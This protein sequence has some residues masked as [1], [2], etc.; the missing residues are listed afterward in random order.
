MKAKLSINQNSQKREFEFTREDFN[1]LRQISNKKTGIVVSDDKFDMFYSRLSRRVRKLSL[2]TFKE[3][4]ELLKREPE[5][6]EMVEFVNSIT[7]NLTAFFRENHHF[8]YLVDC[9]IPELLAKNIENRCI[10]IWSAGCSTGE[11]PYSL[12]I[13]ALESLS[14]K[15]A[16][17]AKILATDIDSNVLAKAADGVYDIERVNGLSNHR[18]RKWFMKGTG[19]H[20][21][22]V[23]T[24]PDLRRQITFGQLNLMQNWQLDAPKD[25]IFCRNVIIYFDK[26]AKTRLIERFAEN[27]KPEGFL[28][29][30]H[31]ESLYKI[32]DRFEL[33][34]QTIYRK[35]T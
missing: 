14:E 1:F 19:K 8:E 27:L 24:K 15:Q 28:F 2:S 23:R 25:V 7:T 34:G 31:S 6:E 3:Y 20:A 16:W 22:K 29:I 18:L 21:G 17:Q 33:I 35:I 32:T 30:G 9:V 4:C 26:E 5:G 11:E 10:D 13:S 12:A